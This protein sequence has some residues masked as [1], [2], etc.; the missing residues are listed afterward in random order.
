MSNHCVCFS[1]RKKSSLN[2]FQDCLRWHHKLFSRQLVVNKHSESTIGLI[3]RNM[4]FNFLVTVF[5]LSKCYLFWEYSTCSSLLNDASETQDNFNIYRTFIKAKLFFIS[6]CLRVKH[7]PGPRPVHYLL[8][9][10]NHSKFCC[11]IICNILKIKF[12]PKSHKKLNNQKVLSQKIFH[13]IPI[14]SVPTVHL[15]W[16]LGLLPS[17]IMEL[18]AGHRNHPSSQTKI[19]L[20]FKIKSFA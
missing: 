11:T 5:L 7:E 10:Q 13:L 3:K 17:R 19:S 8:S 9:A 2:W 1:C 20:V 16:A 6:L 4:H 14:I 15:T 18:C 12:Q